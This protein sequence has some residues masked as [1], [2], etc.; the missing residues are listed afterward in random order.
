MSYFTQLKVLGNI[1]GI[2][3]AVL[4]ATKPANVLQVG[5]NDG[6]NAYGIPLASG[7]GSVVVSGTVTTSVSSAIT[8][9]ASPATANW[10]QAV[11][12][13]SSLGANIIVGGVG[14]QTVR[15]MRILFVNCD[16][17]LTSDV[18]IQ[19]TAPTSFT[20][21]IRFM[22][23]SSFNGTDSNGEPLYISATGK[24]IQLN[25]S[26]AVQLSGTVWYTQS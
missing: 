3:D 23:G 20:G 2:L 17:T 26:V 22:S 7:G 25:T 5:G 8:R 18:T 4:G 11:I 6:T 24:G 19:D 14:G 16:P 9:P 15:V 13:C 1:G 21:P 10:S 12:N